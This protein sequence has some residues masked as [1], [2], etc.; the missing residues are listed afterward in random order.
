MVHGIAFQYIINSPV[1]KQ[2]QKISREREREREREKERGRKEDAT[3]EEFQLQGS[4]G[5]PSR[6]TQ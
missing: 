6:M 1:V 5:Q 3:A 4:K 2:N